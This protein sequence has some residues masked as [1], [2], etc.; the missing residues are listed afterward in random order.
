MIS[1]RGPG[2]MQLTR[3]FRRGLPSDQTSNQT[4]IKG[5]KGWMWKQRNLHLK[6]NLFINFQHSRPPPLC[7]IPSSPH[8]LTPHPLEQGKEM[9]LCWQNEYSA[10]C[11]F[12]F[13]FVSNL[14]LSFF[15]IVYVVLVVLLRFCYF[16][17]FSI[18]F[19]KSFFI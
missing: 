11:F 5:M 7:S 4:S 19:S 6:D 10:L 3:N 1:Q 14:S 8:S 15:L 13:Y 16:L 12:K 9:V 18:L 2:H 17:F